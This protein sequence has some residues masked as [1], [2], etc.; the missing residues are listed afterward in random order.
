[1]QRS[2]ADKFFII[3]SMQHARPADTER[4]TSSEMSVEDLRRAKPRPHNLVQSINKAF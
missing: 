1:M 3:A 4:Y 2:R